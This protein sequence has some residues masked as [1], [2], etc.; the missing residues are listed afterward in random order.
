MKKENKLEIEVCQ[1]QRDQEMALRYAQNFD[2]ERLADMKNRKIPNQIKEFSNEVYKELYL[3]FQHALGQG[4][5]LRELKE[6]NILNPPEQIVQEV[7]E[8]F[9]KTGNFWGIEDVY[10]GTGFDP[11]VSYESAQ[12]GY[13]ILI[14]EKCAGIALD[15]FRNYLEIEPKLSKRFVN[16]QFFNYLND[17]PT[18]LVQ[19]LE[20][21]ETISGM[22]PSFSEKEIQKK[23]DSLVESGFKK[24]ADELIEYI[25][26]GSQFSK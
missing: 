10:I 19:E 24:T 14:E 9:A 8:Q 6:Q 23:Y 5:E 22:K 11:K 3:G 21:L 25:K 16:K 18:T 4:S 1:N 7:Y 12:K 20:Y 17:L 13:K 15:L 26:F 2:Y